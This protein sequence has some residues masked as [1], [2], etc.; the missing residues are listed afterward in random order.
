M[1]MGYQ[2]LWQLHSRGA[3]QRI[4]PKQLNRLA[5]SSTPA[6]NH[7]HYPVAFPHTV[8][9][10][11]RLPICKWSVTTVTICAAERSWKTKQR[12]RG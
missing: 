6:T 1:C 3:A 10:E 12:C 4:P 9:T 2:L 7:R 11:L 5:Q 8:T